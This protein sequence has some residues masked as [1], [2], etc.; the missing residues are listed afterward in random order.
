MY[1]M[2]EETFERDFEGMS[3]T[4]MAPRRLRRE[5]AL[6]RAVLPPDAPSGRPAD[7]RETVLWAQSVADRLPF[8]PPESPAERRVLRQHLSPLQT[9]FARAAIRDALRVIRIA[10]PA[11]P[12][13]LVPNVWSRRMDQLLSGQAFPAHVQLVQVTWGERFRFRG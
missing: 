8:A 4:L 11:A 3:V 1:V 6:L 12:L 10:E 7:E 13:L 2:D 9:R 5:L